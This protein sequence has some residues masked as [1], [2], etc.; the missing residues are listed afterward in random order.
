MSGIKSIRLNKTNREEILNSLVTR[1]EEA[2]P[3]PKGG[4]LKELF[5][6]LHNKYS[7][8]TK[9]PYGNYSKSIEDIRK[10]ADDFNKASLPTKNHLQGTSKTYIIMLRAVI[11]GGDSP[12]YSVTPIPTSVGVLQEVGIPFL[13]SDKRRGR[14]DRDTWLDFGAKTEDASSAVVLEVGLL[15]RDSFN[16]YLS[17]PHTCPIYKKHRKETRAGRLWEEEKRKVCTEIENLLAKFT[18]TK[19]LIEAWPEVANSLPDSLSGK[20]PKSNLP[21]LTTVSLN[22]KLGLPETRREEE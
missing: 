1:W 11:E 22:A 6:A 16:L 10:V 8:I 5:I 14:T 20:A 15:P 18:S 12:A 2:N 3:K 7:K 17:F 4:N 13:V 19:K 21:A 9:G